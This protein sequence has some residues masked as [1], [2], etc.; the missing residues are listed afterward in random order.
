MEDFDVKLEQKWSVQSSDLKEQIQEVTQPKLLCLEYEDEEFK[1][2][3]NIVIDN[4]HLKDVD[5]TL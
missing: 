3:F 2:E 1:E 4:K 5:T